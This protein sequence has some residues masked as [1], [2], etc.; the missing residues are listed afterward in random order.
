MKL[1]DD[2][3]RGQDSRD[4][5]VEDRCWIVWELILSCV[6]KVDVKGNEV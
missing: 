5:E 1:G 2:M 3:E 6:V 4:E